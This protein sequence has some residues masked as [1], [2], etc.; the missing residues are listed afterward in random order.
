[1]LGARKALAVS[2]IQTYSRFAHA[3][4]V[5][6]PRGSRNRVACDSVRS[7]SSEAIVYSE[8]GPPSDMLQLKN[9]SPPEYLS[10][11]SI[12]VHMLAAPINPS[13]IN[14]VE[15]KYP[16]RPQ[17][18]AV[19]GNEGVGVIR[20]VG[21]QVK[22]L[23]RGDWVVPLIAGQGT[24]RRSAHFLADGWHRV[25]NGLPLTTA[26]CLSV[27]P[28][29]A[30]RM[31]KEFVDLCPGDVVVQN[32]GNSGV[33]RAVIQI[34]KAQGLKTVNVVRDRPGLQDLRSE[35]SALGADVVTTEEA[36][37]EDL[38]SLQLPR[39][40]LALNCVG[41]SSSAAV[42]KILQKGGTMVTYGGMSMKPVTVPTSLFIF[43]DL[44]SRGFWVSADDG[45]PE[46]RAKK[47]A[48]LDT[49][50][51]LIQNNGFTSEGQ[52]VRFADFRKALQADKAGKQVLNFELAS[53]STT[54]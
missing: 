49:V 9:I 36:L 51:E 27:N 34:A 31:L 21:S 22:G 12:H 54:N 4:V 6:R 44:R 42:A 40:R 19:G 13:D 32:G 3:Q 45:L 47:A 38:A 43:K 35:L 1:M 2:T 41:G 15:G 25:P 52:L 30:V 10:S 18:P 8:Y 20:E 39:P 23:A 50:V 29:T 14:Q 11:V 24:W 5:P 28:V 26:A 33:G 17:L 37:K 53:D 16:I 46:Q 7:M 48:A